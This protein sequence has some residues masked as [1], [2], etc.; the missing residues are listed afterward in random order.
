MKKNVP[1]FYWEH[2]IQP[3]PVPAPTPA[4]CELQK[5]PGKA[6][7]E[8][9]LPFTP[10]ARQPVPPRA[11]ALPFLPF[12]PLSHPSGKKPKMKSQPL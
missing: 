3:R 1:S 6:S 8:P 5:L 10:P 2:E 12:T 11:A 7:V 4:P 9:E